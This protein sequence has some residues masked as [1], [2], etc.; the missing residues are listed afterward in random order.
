MTWVRLLTRFDEAAVTAQARRA[1]RG[2]VQK[3]MMMSGFGVDVNTERGSSGWRTSNMIVDDTTSQ[4][5]MV[6]RKSDEVTGVE[7]L[8]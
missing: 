7:R 6:I 2:S 4:H 5:S 1:T 3:S 8:F